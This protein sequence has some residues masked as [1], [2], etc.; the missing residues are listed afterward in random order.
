MNYFHSCQVELKIVGK[1]YGIKDLSDPSSNS[2]C[3]SSVRFEELTFATV[4]LRSAFWQG[5][6]VECNTAALFRLSPSG[7]KGSA[8]GCNDFCRFL[9]TDGSVVFIYVGNVGN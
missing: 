7:W 5:W 1:L 9:M 4:V 3:A 2:I 6:V 8:S